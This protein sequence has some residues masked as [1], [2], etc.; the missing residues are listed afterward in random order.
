MTKNR[1][2]PMKKPKASKKLK[3]SSNKFSTMQLTLFVALFAA[4]GFV[5]AWQT[6]AAPAGGQGGKKNSVPPLAITSDYIHNTPNTAAPT[7]CLNE[8]DY[9][10][11]DYFGSLNGSLVVTEELCSDTLSGGMYWDSGGIGLRASAYVTGTLNDLA[12]T[13]P[14]GIVHHAVL[15]SSTVT[16]GVTTNSYA[17]CFAPMY[18]TVHDTSGQPLSNTYPGNPWTYT[19]TGN[20]AKANVS[21]VGQML[22][23]SQQQTYCPP[24]EQNL[25]TP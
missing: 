9:H 14:T 20:F 17:T 19:I 22:V 1:K 23:V 12:I 16:K 21:L 3:I 4:L 18:E 13:S 5:T 2:K 7:S 6:F 10:K 11:R 24:S 15:M 8:D 25:Y